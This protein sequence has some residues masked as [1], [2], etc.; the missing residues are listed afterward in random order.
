MRA[1]RRK[2]RSRL[3]LTLAAAAVLFALFAGLTASRLEAARLE[4]LLNQIEKNIK[5]YSDE[6]Q[7][8]KTLFSSLTSPAKIYDNCKDQW[9]MVIT[10]PKIIYVPA[11]MPPPLVPSSRSQ[12]SSLPSFFDFSVSSVN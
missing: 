3:P 8:L 10:K 12:H 7:K 4:Q 2:E 9:G 1:K 11:T 6:E 5:L